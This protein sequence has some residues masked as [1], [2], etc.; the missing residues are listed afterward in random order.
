[1]NDHSRMVE[2]IGIRNSAFH[3]PI[4]DHKLNILWQNAISD[5]YIFDYERVNTALGSMLERFT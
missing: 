1:M 3:E 2:L 4:A 5:L